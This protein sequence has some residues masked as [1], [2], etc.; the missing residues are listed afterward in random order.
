MGSPKPASLS[1]PNFKQYYLDMTFQKRKADLLKKAGLGEMHVEI[2][3]DQ[4]RRQNVGYCVSSVN[5]EKTG[6]IES[7][8]VAEAFRGM[9]I[10]DS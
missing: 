10:G 6:E 5:L 1:Y 2:A 3:V 4:G 8:F 9:G 7:I